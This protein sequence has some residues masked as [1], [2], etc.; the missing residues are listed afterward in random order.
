MLENLQLKLV[1]NALVELGHA[2]LAGSL[3]KKMAAATQSAETIELIDLIERLSNDQ[4]Y[5]QLLDLFGEKSQLYTSV[6]SREK[7]IIGTYI[8]QRFILLRMLLEIQEG[9]KNCTADD[10]ELFLLSKVVPAREAMKKIGAPLVPLQLSNEEDNY[11][12]ELI[13]HNG[14]SDQTK[15]QVLG[16]EALL[17]PIKS[18]TFL[19][20]STSYGCLS[21]ILTYLLP[22]VMGLLS[23]SGAEDEAQGAA[24]YT[25]VETF[26]DAL[27]Y[28]V[29][30]AP[31]YLTPRLDTSSEKQLLKKVLTSEY[32]NENQ[33]PIHKLHTLRDHVNEVWFA[34]FSPSGRFL[35]TGSLDETC[36]IYDV[37]DD[38]NNIAV[39]TSLP[40]EDEAVFNNQ[41][42]KPA[43]NKRKGVVYI[44]WEP[45]ERYL[46]ICSLDTVIRVWNIETLTSKKRVTRSMDDMVPKLYSCFSLGEGTR[47]WP[48]E[49]LATSKESTPRF[50]VG[51]PDK[52][53][54]AFNI[55]GLELLDFYSDTEEW[56]KVLEE[57]TASNAVDDEPESSNH[58][59]SNA[60][61]FDRVNDLA[62]SPNGKYLVSANNDK[63]VFFYEIPDLT[64]PVAMT[65][66]LGLLSVSGRL[67]SCNLSASGK[68]MLLSIAPELLQVWDISPLE[69][70]E[71]PFLKSILIGLSQALYMIRS[72][73]GYLPL[74]SGMEELI[75][76]GS[77]DGC[78]YIWRLETGQL[79]TKVQGHTGLCN[80]VD[81]NR[82]YNPPKN[83]T[84]YGSYWCSV[85]DDKLVHIWGPKNRQK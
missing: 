38:F 81:W 52:V 57:E 40:E 19:G 35:A 59:K 82:F 5:N 76:S 27:L 63:Q 53:L 55:D 51:S 32:Q 25:L 48:C 16:S 15:F 45:Y 74:S 61:Q 17:V 28:R 75:L 24:N 50:I 18:N 43:L 7:K 37:A 78:I 71:K 36:I 80:S 79:I 67:T 42:F 72:C 23:D 70:G 41:T 20:V 31:F 46:V 60:S 68:Y 49:F 65:N 69:H 2:N 83:G 34:K 66:K 22:E 54:K 8:V 73:F 39:L 1:S 56:Q 84:D 30:H 62:I 47:V 29:T 12:S 3:N 33:F 44:S 77:D 21:L 6:L 9:G 10:A 64:N 26:H 58:Q 85:G 4:D 13:K 14:H 11:L